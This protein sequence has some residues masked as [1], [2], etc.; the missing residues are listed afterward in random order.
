MEH[1]G[2][3]AIGRIVSKD[4]VD[5]LLGTDVQSIDDA[6]RRTME[7]G[8]HLDGRRGSHAWLCWP[9]PEQRQVIVHV[10]PRGGDEW[11]NRLRFRDALRSRPD[12]AAEYEALKIRLAGLTEDWAEYTGMKRAFVDRVLVTALD[13]NVRG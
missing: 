1:I 4:V 12:L 3:T 6:C 7:L 10:V 11:T 5:I 9:G 8:Y 13:D 2:S